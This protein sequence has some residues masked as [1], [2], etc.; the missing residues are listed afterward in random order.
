MH[1]PPSKIPVWNLMSPQGRP[2][3]LDKR[4]WAGFWPCLKIPLGETLHCLSFFLTQCVVLRTIRSVLEMWTESAQPPPPTAKKKPLVSSWRSVPRRVSHIN[5]FAVPVATLPSTP[6]MSL[7]DSV[8]TLAS[9]TVLI[10]T[11]TIKL[12][13]QPEWCT[14]GTSPQ[15]KWVY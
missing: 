3:C 2:P 13:F 15:E 10:V 12:W 5:T 6:P 8:T 11:I 9:I 7:L 4:K 14:I 1:G